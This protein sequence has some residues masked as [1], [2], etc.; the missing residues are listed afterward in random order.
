M[1]VLYLL[2]RETIFGGDGVGGGGA[3]DIVYVE[4]TC[5]VEY[6]EG[7]MDEDEISWDADDIIVEK[8]FIIDVWF[9]VFVITI[10]FV[11]R[12]A[13]LLTGYSTPT[14]EDEASGSMADDGD[15]PSV[16]EFIM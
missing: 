7:W 2:Q 14:F 12:E 13:V 9:D 8:E 11:I 16:D 4:D 6:L 15:I 10:V 3:V 1:M 5:I